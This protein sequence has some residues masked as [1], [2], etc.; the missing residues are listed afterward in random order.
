MNTQIASQLT[1]KL[2]EPIGETLQEL[3]LWTEDA[4]RIPNNFLHPCQII[5]K[6]LI[7][8]I[9]IYIVCVYISVC[10]QL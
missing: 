7:N 6:M 2:F 4:F 1:F 5:E 10:I 3:I 8:P 9:Y